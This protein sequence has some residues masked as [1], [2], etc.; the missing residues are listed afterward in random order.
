[1]KK[2]KSLLKLMFIFLVIIFIALML[3]YT[4]NYNEN[5]KLDEPKLLSEVASIGDYVAY[6]A[7]IWD[8]D[9]LLPTAN[10]P[11]TLGGYS[12]STNMGDGITCQEEEIAKNGW[13]IINASDE[14]ITLVSAGV[15]ECFYLG[16]GSTA[17]SKSLEILNQKYTNDYVNDDYAISMTYLTKEMVDN[18]Y[19]SSSSYKKIDNDLINIGQEYYLASSATS[20]NLWFVSKNGYIANYYVGL[21]GVRPV[22]TLKAN[23]KTTGKNKDNAW[24]LEKVE[25]KDNK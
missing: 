15:T 5:K 14:Y 3:Y 9:K 12:A 1:M 17:A 24:I 6:D 22:I 23:I 2:K 25:E 7:G 11:Y 16:Y 8:Q 4:F 19:G 18:F 20:Y 13:R 21:K 10:I